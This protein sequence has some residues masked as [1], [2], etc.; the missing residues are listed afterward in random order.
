[1]T[2]DWSYFMFFLRMKIENQKQIYYIQVQ[3][4]EN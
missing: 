4:R 1:M 2:A 3:D